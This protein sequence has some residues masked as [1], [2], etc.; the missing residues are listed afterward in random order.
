LRLIK[1]ERRRLNSKLPPNF[2]NLFCEK[3]ALA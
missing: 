2:F 3:S 1:R